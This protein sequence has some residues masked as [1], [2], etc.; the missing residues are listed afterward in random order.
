MQRPTQD[1][2]TV[3]FQSM[4]QAFRAMQLSEQATEASYKAAL[5]K[6]P[7]ARLSSQKVAGGPDRCVVVTA[8]S[9]DT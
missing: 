6:R 1:R 2:E 8:P 7:K 4:S 9:S 5:D 3:T